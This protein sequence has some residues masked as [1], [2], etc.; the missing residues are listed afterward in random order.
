MHFPDLTLPPIN[1][2]N[3]PRRHEPITARTVPSTD[4]QH[5]VRQ[6]VKGDSHIAAEIRRLTRSR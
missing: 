5:P 1:L 2:W 3:V 4:A 6:H